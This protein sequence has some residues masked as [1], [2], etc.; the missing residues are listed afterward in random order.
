IGIRANVGYTD[1][2]WKGEGE[3]S[4]LSRSGW[5]ANEGFEYWFPRPHPQIRSSNLHDLPS[6][7]GLEP[8]GGGDPNNALRRPLIIL[9]GAR[10]TMMG[11]GYGMYETDDSKLDPEASR[12]LRPFLGHVFPGK[13]PPG[14]DSGDPERPTESTSAE[15]N[16]D[17]GVE[18]EWTGIMGFTKNGDPFVGRVKDA[19]GDEVKGQYIVAGF[20]GHGMPRAYGCAEALASLL[21]RDMFRPDDSWSPPEWLPRH[22]LTGT[23]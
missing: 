8:N 10:E 15:C 14:V 2:G 7:S 18:V 1:E 20:T 21:W 5:S 17:D 6:S 12:S 13:F 16:E 23:F 9:G 19:N 22:Y 4:G 11:R 3:K